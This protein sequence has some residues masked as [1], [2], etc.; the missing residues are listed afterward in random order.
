MPNPA[1]EETMKVLVAPAEVVGVRYLLRM[2][3]RLT[4]ALAQT[5]DTTAPLNKSATLVRPQEQSIKVQK[6]PTTST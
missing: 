6:L 3:K 5:S 4:R 2:V 1:R